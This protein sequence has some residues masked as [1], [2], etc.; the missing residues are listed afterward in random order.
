MPINVYKRDARNS[1]GDAIIAGTQ[2]FMQGQ[3][4][5]RK[6]QEQALADAL[7]Q[8][9]LRKI[10]RE[11]SLYDPEFEKLKRQAELE[12]MQSEALLSKAKSS[13]LSTLMPVAQSGGQ[14]PLMPTAQGGAATPLMPN[15]K[16]VPKTY[17]EYG[18]PASY[19]DPQQELEL[20]RMEDE[21]K[22][23]S[24]EAAAGL[25]G[26][27]QSLEQIQKIKSLANERNFGNLKQGVGKIRMATN[28]GLN[29]PGSIRRAVTN[30]VTA[31]TAPKLFQTSDDQKSFELAVKIL[32]P[33]PC[34]IHRNAAP[35]PLA[36][37][38]RLILAPSFF[39]PFSKCE[40]QI[41]FCKLA[42]LRV[43][44]D[45]PLTP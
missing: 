6:R 45:K 34:D 5:K 1:L 21:Q 8:A 14:S 7:N 22:P 11:E 35:K 33:A 23:L 28:L 30:F 40:A 38:L 27:E 29:Q 43:K 41:F 15:G 39:F 26:A 10:G 32:G 31:G 18:L 24:R 12:K 17:D 19:Y 4:Y 20:K 42:A 44:T 9:N 2:G 25:Q 16:L 13:R 37:S 36:C 3:D